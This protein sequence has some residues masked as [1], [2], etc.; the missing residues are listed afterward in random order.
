MRFPEPTRHQTHPGVALLRGWHHSITLSR[1]PANRHY[2]G[3]THWVVSGNRQCA[4]NARYTDD[5]SGR[6]FNVCY[7]K[8]T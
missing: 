7:R 5:E 1:F 6:F 8:T 4:S 3:A 2:D